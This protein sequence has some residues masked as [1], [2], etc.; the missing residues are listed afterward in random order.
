MSTDHRLK[1]MGLLPWTVFLGTLS[2][3]ILHVRLTETR[4]RIGP[5]ILT[6][7]TRPDRRGQVIPTVTDNLRNQSITPSRILGL[8]YEPLDTGNTSHKLTGQIMW[9][10]SSRLF[11]R[12]PT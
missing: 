2:R 5:T 7:E 9:G 1:G 3:D 4:F 12:C 11:S 8:S 6:N 10:K